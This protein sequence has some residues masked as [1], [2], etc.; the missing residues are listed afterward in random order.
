MPRTLAWALL[1]AAAAAAVAGGCGFGLA[2]DTGGPIPA[3]AWGWTCP[4]GGPAAP[5]AGCPAAPDAG[6]PASAGAPRD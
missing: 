2:D 3:D 6:G 5:D 1:V 4:D